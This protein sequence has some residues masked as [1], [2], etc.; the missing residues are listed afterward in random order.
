MRRF[1][2]PTLPTSIQTVCLPREISHHL[3]RVVGIAPNEQVELFDGHGDGC[4]ARLVTVVDGL[5]Q[6]AWVCSLNQT[7]HLPALT[8]VLALTK[9]DAFTTALRMGTEMGVERFVPL[10]A[11]RSIA[12]GDKQ[13]RW[14]KVVTG[15]SAQSKRLDTP[16]VL[17]LQT[18]NTIW[19]ALSEEP[20]W[21][22]HPVAEDVPTVQSITE[23]TTIFVGPEGGFTKQEMSWMSDH[24][25]EHRSLG[26]LVLKADTACIVAAAMA[27]QRP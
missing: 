24:G 5:A 12:K 8:M 27:L 11:Q 9:G 10:Q 16:E 15:A 2:S 3:L 14:N 21:V 18:W 1:L 20:R 22:L 17:S 19:D 6:M 4:V 25:C 13:K 26:R 7:Q 23:A